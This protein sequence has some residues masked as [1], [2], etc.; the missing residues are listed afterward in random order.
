MTTPLG[1]IT[2][3][4]GNL[5]PNF[6]GGTFDTAGSGPA[7]SITDNTSLTFTAT[8]V[9]EPASAS[10]ALLGTALVAFVAIRRRRI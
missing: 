8:T 6:G 1:P 5:F 3:T 4:G 9:P 10:L 2:E 7:I